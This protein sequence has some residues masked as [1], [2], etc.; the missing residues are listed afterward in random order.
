MLESFQGLFIGRG[1]RTVTDMD[2]LDFYAHLQ[3]IPLKWYIGWSVCRLFSVK[4]INIISLLESA[5][6]YDFPRYLI[7]ISFDRH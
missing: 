2:S 6:C 7:F 3:S 5:H 4:I 1:L